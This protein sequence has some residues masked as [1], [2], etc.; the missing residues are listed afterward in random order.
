MI[1]SCNARRKMNNWADMF[2]GSNIGGSHGLEFDETQYATSREEQVFRQA[3]VVE[4]STAM[5]GNRKR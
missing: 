4:T 2:D 3:A 5:K 1:E